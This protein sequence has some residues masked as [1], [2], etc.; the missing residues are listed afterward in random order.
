MEYILLI[1]SNE[2][3]PATQQQWADFFEA[4]TKS[5]L[6]VGGSEISRGEFLG[7]KNTGLL[8][9]LL[10]G[11][12]RFDTDLPNNGPVDSKKIKPEEDSGKTR[13]PLEKLYELLK[14]HPTVM[15]GG[16]VELC[17]MPKS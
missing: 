16:T 13:E 6:F 5:G 3:K 9:E 7:A 14:I 8:S 2:K 11:Y 17:A 1:H 12:M 10:A 15:Q 4:A